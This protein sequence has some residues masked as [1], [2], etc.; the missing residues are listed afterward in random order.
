MPVWQEQAGLAYRIFQPAVLS[1]GVW[2]WKNN[3]LV[4][5]NGGNKVFIARKALIDIWGVALAKTYAPALHHIIGRGIERIL[6]DSNYVET[7]LEKA[8]G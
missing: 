3:F 7:V 2:A 4:H 6:G 1:K 8:R 5:L